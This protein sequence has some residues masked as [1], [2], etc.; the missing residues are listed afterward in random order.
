[1][2]LAKGDCFGAY[3]VI[4]LLGVGGM[5]EVYRARD[6]RL[7]RDVALKVLPEGLAHDAE[8]LAR[9]QREAELLASLNHPN[10]AAILGLEEADGIQG[11]VLEIVEGET[12]AERIVR[13]PIPVAEALPIARQI[14][15]ALEAAHEHGVIHRDLKP[16][17]IK[18]RD[19]ATVK[20]LDFGL[21]KALHGELAAADLSQSPTLSLAA[22]RMGVILGTAAYMSPEQ[23]RGKAVD[24]RTDL[25]AFGCVLYE[26]LSG[27]QA[28][29]G[30][31]VTEILAAVVMKE[32]AFDA[33]PADTPQPIR[34]LLHRCLR[35]DRR[36]RL[37]DAGTARI[38]I[39]EALSAPA[40]AQPVTIP[41]HARRLT[42]ARVAW[43]V[44]GMAIL[45]AS[46]MAFPYVR[47]GPESTPAVRFFVSPPDAWSV[48]VA[49]T[50][51]GA[52]QV[53]LAVAPDGRRIAFVSMSG[54][55]TTQIWV[56]SLDTLAAR[57]LAGT[58]GANSPFWSPDGRFLGFFADGKLKKVDIVG[59]PP[60]T[61]SDA[62]D[63]RGGSWNQEG[64]ILFSPGT[65]PLQKVSAAGGSPSA[66]TVLG[67]GEVRHNRPYF[68]PDGRN[69]FHYTT[70]SN[71]GIYLA[72][73]DSP[74]HT[75]LPLNADAMP[76]I[77]SQGHLLFLR[78]ETLMAQPFDLAAR[79]L[80][81]EAFPIAEQIQITG[82]GSPYSGVFSASPNGVLA[83]RTGTG[84]A[85]TEL[86]WFDRA[87]KPIGVAGD[88]AAYRDIR[89]SPDGKQAVVELPDQS[90]Q[91]DLW[92]YD[93]TRRVRTRFT[94]DPAFDTNPVW[95]PDGSRIAFQFKPHRTANPRSVRESVGRIGQRRSAARGRFGE[96]SRE[97]VSRR[98]RRLVFCGGLR[99][100]G[101]TARSVRSAPFRRP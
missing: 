25:W 90:G 19:D 6:T 63:G 27:V 45:A 18:L 7:K 56:R 41:A 38:E 57:P 31:D 85:G 22:T 30:E 50:S 16:A 51:T 94:F 53:P 11:L 12:L 95:S 36:D 76:V 43:S 92:V 33:L 87:G 13:G 72:S 8:R 59:G 96:R 9:F 39:K 101:R 58:E 91:I 29:R 83:Y 65:G 80:T 47:V 70:G 82:G 73:L 10:I 15:E 20:V 14:A 42:S 17:N 4:G 24:R 62:P 55:G 79:E 5:G 67:S 48:A 28:F 32:P 34:T 40:A 1:M 97:L 98:Q 74:E 75:S 100:Q 93:V 78:E 46:F 21:A 61:L 71:A 35:K 84:P 68:L 49:S 69:F 3:E 81:G 66:A 37:S 89:L 99:W 23:A 52:A 86:R 26:M 2:A 88:S 44:T 77:Y 54:N 64:V 60:I